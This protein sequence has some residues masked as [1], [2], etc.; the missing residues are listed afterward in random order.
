[1]LLPQ[2]RLGNLCP[3][4]LGHFRSTPEESRWHILTEGPGDGAARLR[5]TPHIRMLTN[6]RTHTGKVGEGP[7]PK[8]QARGAPT[9]QGHLSS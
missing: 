3:G 2:P 4:S 9:S 1:M 5:V 7:G 6:T 8:P